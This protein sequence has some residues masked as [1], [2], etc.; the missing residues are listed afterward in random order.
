MYKSVKA[1]TYDQLRASFR[2]QDK[3]DTQ[4]NF[5]GQ[6]SGPGFAN[7]TK[8]PERTFEEGVSSYPEMKYFLL[9]RRSRRRSPSARVHKVLLYTPGYK[10]GA[11]PAVA[12]K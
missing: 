5:Y 7:S 1:V 10:V 6:L 9:Q 11:R 12:T 2:I 8:L 4:L 3:A